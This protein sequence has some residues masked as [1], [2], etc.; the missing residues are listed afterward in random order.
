MEGLGIRE[1]NEIDELAERERRERLDALS[2]VGRSFEALAAA[3]N[4]ALAALAALNVDAKEIGE[5]VLRRAEK[6]G[7]ALKAA[8]EKK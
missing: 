5:A 7:A 6:S 1:I 8:L 2:A 3:N 4:R